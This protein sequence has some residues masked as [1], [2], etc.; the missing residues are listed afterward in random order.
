MAFQ[1][2]ARIAQKQSRAIND[3][4]AASVI[5]RRVEGLQIAANQK[6]IMK[7]SKNNIDIDGLKLQLQ[8][9]RRESLEATRVGDFRK[10]AKLT[11]EAAGLNR[12]IGEAQ[13][14]LLLGL[15]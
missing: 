2:A 3:L 11:T 13:G 1:G 12:A 5:F 7:S 14:L 10:V 15:A 9:V 8:R 4:H 6:R